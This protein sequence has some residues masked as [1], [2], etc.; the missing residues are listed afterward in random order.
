V[1]FVI[2]TVQTLQTTPKESLEKIVETHASGVI[3]IS[4]VL[5]NGFVL[6]S[7]PSCSSRIKQR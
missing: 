5:E 7:F 2:D 6:K 1:F 3:A 4:D